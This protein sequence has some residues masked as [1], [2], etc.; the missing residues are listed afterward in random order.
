M[1][2]TLKC[3][4]CKQD[5]TVPFKQR[6]KKYCNQ[7]CYINAG[8]R[9]KPKQ[10]DLHEKRICVNCGNEFEIRKKQQNKLC[11]DECRREW[12][13]KPENKEKRINESKKILIEKYGVDSLFKTSDGQK[14]A[15]SSFKLKYGVDHP[16]HV[17][18][19]VNKL[20]I[21]IKN[22][23]IPIL[24][25]KLK[26]HNIKLIDEYEQNKSGNTSKS[27]R[28]QCLEC[29]NIF[30]ST[31]LGSGKIPICRKCYPLTNNSTIEQNIKDIL[32]EYNVNFINN[33]KKILNGQEIDLLIKNLSVGFE[34]N[35]NYYHS[36]I[37]GEKDKKYH[38]NKTILSNEKGIKLYHIFEDEIKN[39]PDIVKSRIK[40]I[41]GITDTKIYGRKCTIKEVI[42]SESDT[43]LINN[44]LQGK[45]VD[46]I[47]YGLYYNN[48]LVSLMT[49]GLKRKSLG[50]KT[51]VDDEYELL[52]FCNKIDINVI[53]GFS[54]L[55]NHFIKIFQPN[56]LITYADI[57]WSGISP[58]DTVYCKNGFKYIHTSP[59][60]Y[61]YVSV[62]DFLNRRHRFQYRKDV[63]VKEGFDKSKTE[64]EIMQEKG[65]DRIWDC[66]NMKFEYKLE[67]TD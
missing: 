57:R 65:Y 49:F 45:S 47:R 36:E 26:I 14:N 12:S 48:E 60:N 52:R 58:E 41:L 27:Y 1:N 59:P 23:H 30:T 31:K 2:I 56:N 7:Q 18:E 40:N 34:V 5:F 4:Y 3:E 54:K 61:W 9:G 44:H 51:S 38:I 46:K 67:R 20:K 55:L 37:H 11:S 16:M 43:F 29:D 50:N 15:R 35:G 19:F 22:N 42:K 21:T 32:N 25:D 6:N 53:G 64:W 63:L 13:L 28:F 10:T 66:G 33:E 62:G 17:K 24:I 8:I 39:H